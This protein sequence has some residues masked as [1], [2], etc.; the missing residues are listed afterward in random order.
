MPIFIAVGS[1][2]SLTRRGRVRNDSVASVHDS[3]EA[4]NILTISGA[5]L[6]GSSLSLD[7]D[8]NDTPTKVAKKVR[9]Y[10]CTI[11]VVFCFLFFDIFHLFI[12]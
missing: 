6:A 2:L 9:N 10:K 8:V 12:Y 4:D 1:S 11:Y 7:E 5:H 3:V